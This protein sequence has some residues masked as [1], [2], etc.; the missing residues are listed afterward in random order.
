MK[1]FSVLTAALIF[2]LYSCEN[3]EIPSVDPTIESSE[4]TELIPEQGNASTQEELQVEE[5]EQIQSQFFEEVEGLN[6]SEI[7]SLNLEALDFQNAT[8][9]SE[10]VS[11]SKGRYRHRPRITS[12]CLVKDA[13]RCPAQDRKPTSNMWWPEKANDFDN[14]TTFFS[15]KKYH[16]LIFATFSNG[17]A[18]VRGITTMNEGNCKVYVNVWFKDKQTYEEFTANGGVFKKEPGCAA[19]VTNP[20]DL[21]YY[22]MDSKKSW[23]YSWGDDCIG[24]GC[25]GLEPR[26]E[27]LRGQLGPNGA[28]WDS[29]I[30]EN[31]FSDWGWI[32][33]RH[34]GE[35]LWVMD[36]NFRL[37]CCPAYH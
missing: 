3:E 1:K 23:L 28:A 37:H 16:R 21:H 32:T 8:I 5:F 24:K 12:L 13:D 9:I 10:D 11:S 35:H 6:I 33:D 29:N 18:L 30:G 17:T 4:E 34:T 7:E 26:G 27:N 22:E 20:A 36:F 2:A 19:Q 31:G 25:F 15:S 14:P